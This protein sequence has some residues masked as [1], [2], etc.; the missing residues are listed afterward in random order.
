MTDS[1]AT[2]QLTVYREA[3][4]NVTKTK[5][6]LRKRV[7]GTVKWFNVKN[8]YGLIKHNDTRVDILVH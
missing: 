5:A 1:S 4:P 2:E 7:P 6:V 3:I 8:E